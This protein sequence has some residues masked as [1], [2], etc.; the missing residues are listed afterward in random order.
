MEE[1]KKRL[2]E[3]GLAVGSMKTGRNNAITDVEGVRAGH[4]AVKGGGAMTGVTVILP[5]PGNLFK[6][7]VRAAVYT[8]NGY[9]KAHGFEQVRE[10]GVIESP[11][12][13]TNTLNVGLVS[14][15]LVRYMIEGNPEI[16]SEMAGMSVNVVVGETNDAA[17]NDTTKRFVRYEHVKSAIDEAFASGDFAAVCEGCA[18]AGAGT[19]AFG[20]KGGIGTSSRVLEER[21]G[22]FTVGALVQTNFGSPGNLII[23]GTPVGRYLSPEK[24]APAETE[25]GSVMVV[26]AT[27][28]PLSERQLERIA[29]RASAGLARTGSMLGHGSGDF[30]IAFT[31][32]NKRPIKPESVCANISELADEERVIPY[33]FQAVIEVVEE[34]VVNSLFMAETTEGRGK[35]R[36]ALPADEVVRI[37]REFQNIRI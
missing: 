20:W 25:K 1:T 35:I 19:T 22:G 11:V 6:D 32:Q 8:I 14:D 27:D 4:A 9:G 30:V 34:A 16:G 33:L 23:C 2:R 29:K 18:G 21:F 36:K 37:I 12:A 5:H 24:E 15:A 7:K 31:T 17:L 3:Y 13:L 26:L 10:L 28:A